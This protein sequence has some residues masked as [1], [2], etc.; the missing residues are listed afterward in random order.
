MQY[1]LETIGLQDEKEKI[2]RIAFVT[3]GVLPVPPTKGGAVRI[4]F[5][6]YF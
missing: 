4:W 6:T 1:S 3:A 2:S 5:I